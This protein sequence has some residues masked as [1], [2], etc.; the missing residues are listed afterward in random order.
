M[1]NKCPEC[2]A[3]LTGDSS[4]QSIFESLLAFEYTKP[5]YG[6]VHLFS[7]A[8]Y[9]I[10][11][12]RYSDKAFEWIAGLLQDYLD[13]E[14]TCE[15]VKRWARITLKRWNIYSQS[16]EV[17]RY[18]RLSTSRRVHTSLTRL[19]FANNPEQLLFTV[20]SPPSD[21]YGQMPTA[22]HHQLR[23]DERRRAVR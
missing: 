8:C 3:M 23:R 16:Y 2:C 6:E 7:V 18:M 14:S 19:Q 4:C 11:H 17:C 5:D 9:M 12:L 10:Q 21:R 1:L 15:L 20:Q 22:S 13:D